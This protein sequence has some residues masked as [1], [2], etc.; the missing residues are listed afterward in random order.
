MRAV[1]V[2][3]DLKDSGQTI[4][5]LRGFLRD[6]AVDRFSQLAGLRLKFWISDRETDRWGAVL[7]WESAE[8]A[9]LA[10]ALP[11]RAAEL[12]GYPPTERSFFDVEATAEGVFS[13]DRLAGRG[14]ALES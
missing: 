2:W 5:S 11:N 6:E 8:S 13:L 10:A 1:I 9:A 4:D 3:W 12:I 7:L 14:L